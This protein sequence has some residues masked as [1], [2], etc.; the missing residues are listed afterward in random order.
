MVRQ[1]FVPLICSIVWAPTSSPQIPHH[2]EKCFPTLAQDI[3]QRVEESETQEQES[4][5]ESAPRQLRIVRLIFRGQTALPPE[6]LRE[7]AK[8]LKEG[9]YTDSPEWREELRERIRDAW[10]HRGYFKAVVEE[11]LVRQLAG[12]PL[13]KRFAVNMSVDAGQLYRLERIAFVHS[14]EFS[15]GELRSF[16]AIEDG[17]I[18]DTHKIQQGIEKMRKAYA[19]KGFVNFT[20]VPSFE[21][22]QLHATAALTLELDEGKQL[23]FGQIKVLGMDPVLAKKLLHESG[24]EPGRIFDFSLMSKFFERNR[25]I[26]PADAS[27]FDDTESR[28]DEKGT[29]DIT[30]DVRGCLLLPEY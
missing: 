30:I 5:R 26:L 11:L 17:D 14:T 1:L 27:P 21:I 15:A 8:S 29:V 23:H 10:Q 16:F 6:E 9:R 22:D 7:I 4:G 12:T 18:F 24:L 13:E 20:V 3:H 25:Q 19:M 2:L 28:I